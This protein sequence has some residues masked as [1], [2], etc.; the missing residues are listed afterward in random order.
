MKEHPL[1]LSRPMVHALQ[2]TVPGVWPPKSIDA[3]QPFKWQTRRIVKNL[4]IRMRTTVTSDFAQLLPRSALRAPKGHVYK[5]HLNQHGAVSAVM[6]DGKTL[7]VKPG[8]FDFLCPYSAAGETLLVDYGGRK[9]WEVTVGD[10]VWFR[11]TWHESD[12]GPDYFAADYAEGEAPGE[13]W[14]W[15]PSI[16]MPRTACRLFGEIKRLRLVRV[17]D[18]SDADVRAEG[19]A[20]ADFATLRAAWAAGWDS[21]NWHRAPYAE[22]PWVWAIDFMRTQA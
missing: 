12:G 11:E 22:S 5:A 10:R 15:R 1:L 3:S 4:R 16:Y 17:C 18:I 9:G 13:D 7:G 2:N 19:V 8:E 6:H 21:L 20:Q 14:R